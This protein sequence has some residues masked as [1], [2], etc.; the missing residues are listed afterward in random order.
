MSEAEA[1]L[2][3][4]LA[5][6]FGALLGLE[7]EDAD[8]PAGVRTFSIVALGSA[9]F[10]VVSIMTFGVD[11]AGARIPAQIVTGIGFLG[12]GVIIQQ[13]GNVVGLTTAA[14]IWA[15]AAAGMG[16]GL[17]LYLVA[18]GGVVILLVLLRLIGILMP[19]RHSGPSGHDAGGHDLDTGDDGDQGHVE[20]R[21]E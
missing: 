21:R 18:A 6:G 15:A 7:R 1:L 12:A 13:R 8:K 16:F 2:R 19:G 9:L 11:D 17:G 10:C 14:G 5:A 20:S 4:V 3:L